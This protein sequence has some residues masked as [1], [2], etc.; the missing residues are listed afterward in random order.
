[1]AQGTA[2]TNL[3]SANVSESD[4]V[5]RVELEIILDAGA[6]EV[7]TALTDYNHL[8]QLSPSIAQS[9]LLDSP[10]P[11]VVRIHTEVRS[12]VVVSCMHL[13]RVDDIKTSE[14]GVLYSRIVLE[15]S[16]FKSGFSEWRVEPMGKQSR[17]IFRVEFEPGFSLPPL[18]GA[19]IMKGVLRKELLA[20]L[21]NLEMVVMRS[22][23]D[24]VR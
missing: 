15:M 13:N 19:G 6:A 9:K 24:G 14:S 12:C 4:N 2:A 16:D 8:E 11:R 23:T 17:V 7:F 20:S 5:Y 22:T 18:V 21:E 10:A 1:M 3:M